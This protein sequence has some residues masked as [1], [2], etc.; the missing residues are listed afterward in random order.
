M[1][2]DTAGATHEIVRAIVIHAR[3]GSTHDRF[4][5]NEVS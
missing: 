5:E 2:V 1:L 4:L 3:V